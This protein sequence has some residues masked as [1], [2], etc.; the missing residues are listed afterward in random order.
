MKDYSQKKHY[1]VRRFFFTLSC[2]YLLLL[3]LA[4]LSAPLIAPYNPT[5]QFLDKRLLPPCSEGHLLGSD[6][7]GRDILSRLIYG[8]RPL[9]AVGSISVSIALAAGLLL[10]IMAGL[11]G[12]LLGGCLMLLIDG[13]LCF[14]TVLL[15]ITVISLFGYG[16]AQMILT[17]GIVFTPVFARIVRAETKSLMTE[18]FVE[19]SRALGTRRLKIVTRHILPNMLPDLIIQASIL[20]ASAIIIEASLSF[21]GL[22][23]QPPSPSWGLMLKDA[24]GY[25]FQAPYLAFI[26]GIALAATIF[27]LNFIGD[28][29]AEKLN[30]KL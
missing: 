7:L 30:P 12:K 1:K 2:A 6:E 18:G 9:L 11:R 10:G 3:I 29:V 24:R 15:V 26:P 13:I 22:G 19:S 27:S 23:V 28:V 16:A 8:S 21:L 17:I 25:I 14:P 5:S 20:F 4:A